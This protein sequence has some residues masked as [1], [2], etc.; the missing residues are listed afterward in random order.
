MMKLFTTLMTFLALASLCHSADSS[1]ELLVVTNVPLV[2]SAI[3]INWPDHKNYKKGY[4]GGTKVEL[5][6]ICERA[7]KAPFVYITYPKDTTITY[8]NKK[9]S[10]PMK[11]GTHLIK[12]GSD[13]DDF[14]KKGKKL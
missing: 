3:T 10:I 4:S 2:K 13:L 12:H 11:V 14:M 5:E 7:G 9:R 6:V 1:K 8:R